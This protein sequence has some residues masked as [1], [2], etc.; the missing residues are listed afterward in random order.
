VIPGVIPR[1]AALAVPAAVVA[2]LLFGGRSALELVAISVV[3]GFALLAA[4]ALAA[5]M[6]A[7]GQFPPRIGRGDVELP[8]EDIADSGTSLKFLG[9]TV[10]ELADRLEALDER[11]ATLE[12][13]SAHPSD[14]P[15]R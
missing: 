7:T 11:V 15:D 13:G 6:L 4:V 12:R 1:V 3:A 8:P 10:E 5:Y 9:E 14:G 2:V